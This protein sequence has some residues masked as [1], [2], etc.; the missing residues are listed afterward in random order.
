MFQISLIS[1]TPTF[2]TPTEAVFL[3]LYVISSVVLPGLVGVCNVVSGSVVS[4]GYLL[5]IS[6]HPY[7][8]FLHFQSLY[9][10]TSIGYRESD[11]SNRYHSIGST[12]NHKHIA[13]YYTVS[14]AHFGLSGTIL[15]VA[16][17]L[18]VCSSGGNSPGLDL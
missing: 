4:G 1:G 16:I 8:S 11:V 6:V 12:C 10:H 17:R 9:K 5:F 14:A 13:L 15:S 3:V 2:Q 18:E 7:Y